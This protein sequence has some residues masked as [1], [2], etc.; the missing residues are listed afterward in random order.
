MVIA[1]FLSPSN[2]MIDVQAADKTQLLKDLSKRAAASVKL[3]GD[4]VSKA[5]LQ[6]ETL[7]STG[8][9]G[10]VAI[11]HARFPDLK[12]PFG[13]LARLKKAIEFEAIDSKPVDVVFLLLLPGTAESAQL[14][15][16]AGVARILRD[17]AITANIRRANDGAQIYRAIVTPSTET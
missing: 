4:K 3:D 12:K 5:I 8:T 10:G 11:P 6:R 16:L 13:I 9:G 1:D 14:N 17:A 2:V 15:A 7:G